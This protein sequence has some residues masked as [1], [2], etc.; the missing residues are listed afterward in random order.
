MPSN[1]YDLTLQVVVNVRVSQVQ[2]ASPEAAIDS[3]LDRIDLYKLF[4][5]QQP[6]PSVSFTEY[7]EEV[8]EVLV[9]QAGDESFEHSQWYGWRDEQ[10]TPLSDR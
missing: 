2:A 3:A 8:P 5:R 9:D 6:T 4:A 7:A 10:W 1:Q